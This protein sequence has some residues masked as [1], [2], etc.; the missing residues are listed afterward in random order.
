MAEIRWK[1]EPD[2]HDY[3]AAEDYLSLIMGEHAAGNLA[4][5]LEM[6]DE[7][8]EHPAKDIIR[9]AGFDTFGILTTPHDRLPEHVR[10]NL[11]KIANGERLSPVLL[12]AGDR[13]HNIPLTVADGWHRV[14]AAYLTDENAVIPAKLIHQSQKR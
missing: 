7:I 13:T 12:I 10:T 1:N 3:G 4:D 8:V 6:H 14:L 5:R 11:D 2:H 9:A